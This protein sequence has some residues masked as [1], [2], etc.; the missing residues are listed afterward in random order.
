MFKTIRRYLTAIGDQ[1][2]I[3]QR[4]KELFEI[5][6]EIT[7]KRAYLGDAEV[8][9]LQVLTYAEQVKLLRALVIKKVANNESAE[10]A[11]AALSLIE[12]KRPHTIKHNYSFDIPLLSELDRLL[13]VS[14]SITALAVAAIALLVT[15]KP[16]MCNAIETE[17]GWKANESQVCNANRAVYKFFYDYEKE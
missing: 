15:L 6:K 16:S 8:D 1:Q 10:E 3:D 17:D 14:V 5:E 9:D 4:T 11:F 12:N 2:I 13:Y 7:I